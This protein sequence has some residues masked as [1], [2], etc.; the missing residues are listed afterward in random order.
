MW[1]GARLAAVGIAEELDTSMTTIWSAGPAAQLRKRHCSFWEVDHSLV[2][3]ENRATSPIQ[4][5]HDFRYDYS[6]VYAKATSERLLM[7]RNPRHEAFVRLLLEGKSEVDAHQR[8]GYPRDRDNAMHI[9]S[10]MI[11]LD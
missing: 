7:L 4:L 10:S 6:N 2:F 11:W 5:R 8:A 3:N 9:T 1:T